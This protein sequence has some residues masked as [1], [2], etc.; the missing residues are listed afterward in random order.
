MDVNYGRYTNQSNIR[1]LKNG[2]ENMNELP[3]S[4]EENLREQLL[5][6]LLSHPFSSNEQKP[7]LFVGTL[8]EHFPLNI[9]FPE[10]TRLLGTLVR[11]EEQVEI[12]ALS[13]LEPD[14]VI[15]FYKTELTGQGWKE[16]EMMHHMGGFLHSRMPNPLHHLTLC[17]AEQGASLT[18]NVARRTGEPTD[19]RLSVNLSSEGNPCNQPRRRPHIH[20]S[21]HD[22]IPVIVPPDGGIQRGGGGGGSDNSWYTGATLTSELDLGTLLKHYNGQLLKGGWTLTD[23]D[24][25]DTLAWSTWTHTDEDKEPWNAFFLIMSKPGKSGQYTLFI[26]TEWDQPEEKNKSSSWFNASS[27][28][29]SPRTRQE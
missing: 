4:G 11:G 3:F 29:I 12:V 23:T 5:M 22:M 6:Q 26:R 20:H 24:N 8:P 7:A 9:P 16:P 25:K 15:T 14:D 17:Q 1:A 13:D 28:I 10:K 2:A 27:T 21:R 18:I 19:I